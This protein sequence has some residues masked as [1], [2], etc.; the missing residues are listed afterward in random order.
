MTTTTTT[1]P[2]TAPAEP[3]TVRTFL[4]GPE[5]SDSSDPADALAG[6]LHDGGATRQ[7]LGRTGRPLSPAA[8]H[9]VEHQLAGSIDSFL[10]LDV[11]DIAAGGWRRHAALTDA[12]HRT[13]AAPG[14]EEIVALA[15]HEIDSHHHPYIDVYVDGAKIGTLDVLLDL[16]FRIDGLVAVVRDAH[17]VAIRSGSCVLDAMLAAQ[18]IPLA[19]RQ[20]TL[21]LPGI[22]RLHTPLPILTADRAS[23]PDASPDAPPNPAS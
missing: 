16:L 5:S 17:I 20:G 2:P 23:A 8:D 6:P 15:Q 12:A 10:T 18:E 19:Q 1:T 11:F 4:L 14:S 22:W 13:R 21:D 7:L 9:A 3:Y